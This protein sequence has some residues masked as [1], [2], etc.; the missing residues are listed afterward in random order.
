MARI[1]LRRGTAAQWTSANPV[2]LEGELGLE[3]DTGKIKVGDG[4]ANWNTTTYNVSSGSTV[5]DITIGPDNPAS[6]GGGLSYDGATATLTFTPAVETTTSLSIAANVL[7]YTDEDGVDTDI[8]L[9][10]YLDDT[11]LARIVSG[12]MEPTTRICTFTRD[13]GS[14][15]DIDFSP[16]LHDIFRISVGAD[17]STLHE[18]NS[19]ESIKFIGGENTNTSSNTEGDITINVP[20][21]GTFRGDLVGSVF[22]DDSTTLIDGIS[23][24]IFKANIEDSGTWDTAYSWGDHS[25]VGY[26]TAETNDLSSVVTWADVPDANITESSVTQ[27]Q[28][29]LSITESQISDLQAYLTT[30]TNDLT[31]A[32][33]WANVPDVNITQSSVTQHQAAL[34]ITESQ[35]SDLQAYLLDITNESIGSL[36]DV[37]LTSIADGQA[38]VYD[39]ATSQWVNGTNGNDVYLVDGGTA[40]S[41]YTSGDLE[42]DGGGA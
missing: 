8:D 18:I 41:I 6:G 1:Q 39:S 16:V 25:I 13:D 24:T 5:A 10:L 40:T 23:G 19:G 7:T 42:L 28:A 33:T 32:V 12:V 11:N 15:F 30:E 3:T 35:I 31:A 20:F 34:S 4:V 22:A 38:L 29:A 17:D 27:H 26:L 2:L 21:T 37:T 36:T 9:S 14:T